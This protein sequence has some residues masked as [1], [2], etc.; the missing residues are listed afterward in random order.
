MTENR[1]ALNVVRASYIL[2]FGAFATGVAALSSHR[3]RL[4]LVPAAVVFGWSQIG[5]L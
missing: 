1:T 5:G 3:E 2:F 4:A